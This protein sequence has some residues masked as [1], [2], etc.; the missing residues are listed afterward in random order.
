MASNEGNPNKLLAALKRYLPNHLIPSNVGNYNSVSWPFWY[1]IN[2]DFGDTYTITSNARQTKFFQVTEEACLLLMG[3]YRKSRDYSTAGELGPWQI[4]IKDR[5][6]SRQFNDAPIPIQMIGNKSTPTILPT[7]MIIMPNA[8]VDVTM[9]SW[10]PQGAS[11]ATVGSSKHQF[12]FFG[13]RT[14]IEDAAE[15]MSLIYG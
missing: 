15:I 4:E 14:R 5:Q 8:F 6:S 1:P 10:I 11:Q 12:A 7:P 2:F 13:Y 3:I 9:S